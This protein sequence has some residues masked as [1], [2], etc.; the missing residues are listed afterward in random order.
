MADIGEIPRRY[1][2]SGVS[3]IGC[4][5]GDQINAMTA[6]WVCRASIDPPLIMIGIGF[7]RRSYPLIKESGE[8]TIS[9]LRE[10]QTDVARHFGRTPKFGLEKFEGYPY[11]T[12]QTG[13]PMLRDCLATME[14]R[15]VSSFVTGDHEWFV[16]DIL[17][18]QT[19]GQGNPLIYR[20]SDYA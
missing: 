15:V 10:G 20:H 5:N 19:R 12:G 16:G 2:T 9:V 8:F 7:Q 18:E 11:E 4:K 6:A 1:V 3:V 17:R 14:C 13:A